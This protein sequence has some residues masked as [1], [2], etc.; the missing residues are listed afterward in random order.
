MPNEPKDNEAFP[1]PSTAAFRAAMREVR[2]EKGVSLTDAARKAHVAPARLKAVE[3]GQRE[4]DYLLWTRVARAIGTTSVEFIRRAELIDASAELADTFILAALAR[5][6]LHRGREGVLKSVL[7]QHLGLP[8]GVGSA[9]RLGPR[10]GELVARKLVKRFRSRGYELITLTPKG[11]KVL[12]AAEPVALPESPQHREWR[13]G[14][15]AATKRI[16]GFRDDL[17]SALDA[18]T[19]LLADDATESDAFYDLAVRL[20]KACKRVGSATY[21]LREWGEP[22]DATVDEPDDKR[23]GHRNW[24]LWDWRSG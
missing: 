16:Q 19:Q 5:A 13:E 2:E 21:C 22:D 11:R 10:L 24:R 12:A 7:V 1:G 6:Q 14:Q 9:R 15:A 3:E 4:P 18:G 20:E 8:E 23:R 17:R